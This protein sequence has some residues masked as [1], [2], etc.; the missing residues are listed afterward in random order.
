MSI[1]LVFEP[2]NGWTGK[3][4][5]EELTVREMVILVMAAQGN[6]NKEIADLLGI[7]YQTVKNSFH[8]LTKKLGAK[9]SL[10]ALM[11]A[12][13]AGFIKVE[14]VSDEIDGSLTEEERERVRKRREVFW[15][16][17]EKMSE[18]EFREYMW[19]HNRKVLEQE[20]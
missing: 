6:S 18:E 3:A 17:A 11:L 14:M 7:K 9:N 15:K 2:E 13:Q 1:R 5:S 10:H 8:K 12:M 16:K 20:E 19:E 4:K